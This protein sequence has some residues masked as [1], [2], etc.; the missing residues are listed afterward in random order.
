M[1]AVVPEWRGSSTEI[2]TSAFLS[3]VRVMLLT[4]PMGCPATS[5]WLPLTS[6]PPFS[7]I[8]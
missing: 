1:T 6:W 4:V 5:T 3:S 2:E 8:R 7:K